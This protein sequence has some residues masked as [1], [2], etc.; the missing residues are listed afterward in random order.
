MRA[1]P[2]L[3]VAFW[4][5]SLLAVEAPPVALVPA[6]AEVQWADRVSIPGPG[7]IVLPNQASPAEQE[8]AGL[9]ARHV[10]RR[11]GQRWT[12]GTAETAPETRFRL[13]LGQPH[14]FPA[15]DRLCRDQNL[16]VPEHPEGYALKIWPQGQMVMAIVAGRTGRAVIY[17]QDTLFQLF[18]R[19][20]EQLTIQMATIRDWPTIPLR[21]RPH[22]HYKIFLQPES[23]DCLMTS[24]INFIDLRDGVYAFEPGAKLNREEIGRIIQEASKR[25]LRVYATVNCGVTAEEQD[26]VINLFK[27]FIDLGAN[28]LWASFDDRG[29]GEA[30]E[31]MAAKVIALGQAHGLTG[32]AIAITPP[33][34]S[35]QTITTP[36]NQAIAAVPGMEQATWFWTRV[37]CAED[38][39][40][41]R[42]IGL[43]IK[44]SWWHN[45]PRVVNTSFRA[46]SEQVYMPVLR[47]ADGWH[48]PNDQELREMGDYVHAVMPWDG[49]RVQQHYL[50]PSIGWWAWRP[51]Q[52]DF[53]ALR[54]RMYD[55]VY[56]PRQ[57]ETAAE[58]DDRLKA[59]RERF[60]F[61]SAQTDYA[62]HCPPRLKSVADR[63]RTEQE[64]TALR[65]KLPAFRQAALSA[66]LLAQDTLKREYLDPLTLELETA[67]AATQAPYPEYWWPA[68]Q[69]AVLEAIYDGDTAGADRLIAGVRD[70]VLNE[71]AQV[72]RLLPHVD[73]IDA[74][75]D[76]WRKRAQATAADWQQIIVKR[77]AELREQMDD[78][79][80][81]VAPIKQMLAGLDDPPIQVGVGRWERR[82]R[83]RATVTPE[84]RE[85]WWGDWIGGLYEHGQTRVAVFAVP[86]RTHSD[87][88]AYAEMPVN[89]PISGRRDRLALLIYLADANKESYGLGRAKWRWSGFRAIRLLWGER[90]LW[91]ADLGIPR[92]SGEWFVVPLPELPAE[93][94]SL[95]L[96]L[97]VEDYFSAR[98]NLQIVFVGPIRL[99]ELDRD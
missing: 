68:H 11:F 35:Y 97:R 46:G 31:K 63:A 33:K 78:Y 18:D 9:L 14:R 2:S 50:V 71:V 88:G 8:A 56:G 92:L 29:P 7:A 41:A 5:A 27:E 73:W 58:F 89:V 98:N 72:R 17:G 20:T 15:L 64:L 96:R 82:N 90:E 66:S 83:V 53:Q 60:L 77:Q 61:W 40:E 76:W 26:A 19:Q 74:Y 95:N 69:N 49:W 23:F 59:I 54:Q 55:F 24:R 79:N 13:Y 37:P 43:R 45:W 4:P 36:F 42:A 80:R 34:G 70:R 75:A 62:A 32:D 38:L 94:E 65:D 84:P 48:H 10:E 44:P 1:L 12:I 16:S 21:G 86:K 3:L 22:P 6:A 67:L 87:A 85:T 39:A 99:L 57:A 81:T 25:E 47:L 51:E 30:P 93:I 28:G 52:Y 91:K